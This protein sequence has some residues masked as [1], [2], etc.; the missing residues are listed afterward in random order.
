[1]SDKLATGVTD[2]QERS[3]EARITINGQPL[4]TAQSMTIRV[5]LSLF[6]MDMNNESAL[7]GDATG[8]DI[9][10]NY[11][12]RGREIFKLIREVRHT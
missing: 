8:E 2:D 7:G 6:L 10:Q 5:A 11:L 1:M 9:R 12:A 4:T 3:V